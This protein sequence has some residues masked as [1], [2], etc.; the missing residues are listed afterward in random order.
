MRYTAV[1]VN[2]K[3]QCL[4]GGGEDELLYSTCDSSSQRIAAIE[5]KGRLSSVDVYDD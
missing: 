5:E 1:N 3:S 2:A 4:C